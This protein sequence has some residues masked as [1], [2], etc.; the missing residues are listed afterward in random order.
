MPST[1]RPQHLRATVWPPMGL[2]EPGLTLTAST[3]PEIA[4]RKPMSAGLIASR[5]RTCAVTGSVI[6]L[7]S[8]PAQ[9]CAS[10][11][12]PTCACASMKPGSTHDPV[13]SMT[14]TPSGTA[15]PAPTAAIVPSVTRTIPPSIAG[16]V[17]GTTRPPTIATDL[18]AI[19][20]PC[21]ISAV[22]SAWRNTH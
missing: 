11:C 8:W 4:S 9:P 15:S 12:T 6:S 7:V 5:A 1:V 21:R 14:G 20:P 22:V 18:P 2:P 19:R 13:A 17:T 3:P 16:P 10:S